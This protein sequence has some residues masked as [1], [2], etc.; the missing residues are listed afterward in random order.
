MNRGANR[1]ARRG[2]DGLKARA[3]AKFGF[4]AP[5]ASSTALS[6]GSGAATFTRATVATYLDADAIMQEAASGSARFSAGRRFLAERA[7]TNSLVRSSDLANAAWTNL[8]STKA[9]STTW[10][11][12]QAARLPFRLSDDL[13]AAGIHALYQNVTVTANT[14]Y[15]AAVAVH[16]SGPRFRGR[17]GFMD[18]AAVNGVVVEF[19]ARTGAVVGYVGGTGTLASASSYGYVNMGRGWG[20]VWVAGKIDA[21]TT[22]GQWNLLMADSAGNLVYNGDG[23]SY[24]LYDCPQLEAG[25]APT[26]WIPTVAAALTRNADVLS[27]PAAGNVSASGGSMYLEYE[28]VNDLAADQVLAEISDGTANERITVSRSAVG[29]V[30]VTVVDGGATQATLNLGAAAIGA[31]GKVAARWAANDIAGIMTGGTVQTDATA[32]LP[33][34][35]T[36]Y[37]GNGAGVGQANSRVANLRISQSLLTN[38]ELATLVQ[39]IEAD[40]R[41]NLGAGWIDSSFISRDGRRL[42]FFYTPWHAFPF[43]TTG[44]T[45]YPRSGPIRAGH[46]FTEGDATTSAEL[47]CAYLRHDRSVEH[48]ERLGFCTVAQSE[49]SAMEATAVPPRVLFTSGVAGTPDD[50]YE[51]TK[52]SS[53]VWSVPSAANFANIAAG[54]SDLGYRDDNPHE[55]FT[56]LSLVFTSNRPGGAGAKDL[57]MSSRASTANP[58]GAPVNAGPNINSALDDDQFFIHANGTNCYFSRDGEIWHITFTGAVFNNDAAKCTF[59]G[60]IGLWVGEPSV[61][62]DFLWMYFTQVD[63]STGASRIMRA[64]FGSSVTS[65]G[66]PVA[67]D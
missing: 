61:T 39:G 64:P 48:V 53:G 8:Q 1:T 13:T 3:L 11:R 42:Y 9:Q 17:L 32:T 65:W 63:E 7:A 21:V 18:A 56:G 51:A 2:L 23:A 40:Q 31:K 55:V 20:L 54:G 50:L 14:D 27:Y 41:V 57:W 62:D 36:I 5:L 59:S 47:Y 12:L 6:R 43:I 4:V 67:V 25:A 28:I 45:N 60:G 52:D 19:N 66:V 10:P 16:S 35:T 33:T 37:A 15:C 49:A 34:V 29:N 38:I 30:T 58:W 22:A 24:L 26:S 46:Q 44:D